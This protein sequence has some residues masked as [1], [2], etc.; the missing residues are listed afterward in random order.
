VLSKEGFKSHSILKKVLKDTLFNQFKIYPNPL[1]S[2]S[3]L[4]IEWKQKEFGNHVLELF[5]QSG[6]LVFSKEIYIDQEAK[7]LE[8]A[9]PGLSAGDYFLRLTGKSTGASHLQKLVIN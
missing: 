3:N 9:L 6:Q 2:N 8:V 4:H 5:N 1:P 7:L